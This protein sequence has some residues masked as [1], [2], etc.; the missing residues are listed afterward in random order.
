VSSVCVCVCVY[1]CEW[2]FVETVRLLGVDECGGPAVSEN[3]TGNVN[4]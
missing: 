2:S 3:N 4:Y 1:V